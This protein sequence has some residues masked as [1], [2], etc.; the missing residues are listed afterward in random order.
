MS[1][2]AGGRLRTEEG[3]NFGKLSGVRGPRTRARA[4]SALRVFGDFGN[5]GDL[6][7]AQA[8][9]RFRCLNE[10]RST[11]KHARILYLR[12]T[13]RD[14][15]REKSLQILEI[16]IRTNTTRS[17]RRE[18]GVARKEFRVSAVNPTIAREA[19]PR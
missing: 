16:K 12:E 14:V 3:I 2:R 5:S 18:A 15:S 9:G 17:R 1:L 4:R 6:T 19:A 11:R 7:V 13:L 10:R 8:T